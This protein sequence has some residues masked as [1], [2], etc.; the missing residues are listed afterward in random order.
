MFFFVFFCSS[1]KLYEVKRNPLVF[2]TFT[3]GGE[4]EHMPGTGK[5]IIMIH[6][7]VG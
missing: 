5:N 2:K 1:A 3:E 7:L 6:S 4:Q